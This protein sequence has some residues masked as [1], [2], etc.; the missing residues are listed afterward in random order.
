MNIVEAESTVKVGLLP[1][2]L[3][4]FFKCLTNTETC[5][6]QCKKKIKFSTKAT[7]NLIMHLKRCSLSQY[8]ILVCILLYF[9][10]YNNS[11]KL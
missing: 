9:I 6:N 1:K 4:D 5:C 2:P 3:A 11:G 7:S 8:T 10:Q